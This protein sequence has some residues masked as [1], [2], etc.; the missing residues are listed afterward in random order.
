M[1]LPK[2]GNAAIGLYILVVSQNSHQ[3]DVGQRQKAL[4]HV[5]Q[6]LIAKGEDMGRICRLVLFV[7]VLLVL[8]AQSPFAEKKGTNRPLSG[9]LVGAATIELPPIDGCPQAYARTTTLALGNVSHLGLTEA[10]AQHCSN[11]DGSD[12]QN[13][14]LTLTASNGDKLYATYGG[15]THPT[16]LA[17]VGGTGRFENATATAIL[18][19]KVTPVIKDGKPDFTVPWPWEATIQGKISY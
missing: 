18:Y 13:G 17:F 8:T 5:P 12:F 19:W 6:Y 16:V 2:L 4:A 1:P 9:K 11:A 14:V 3:R 15:S 10:R 7:S